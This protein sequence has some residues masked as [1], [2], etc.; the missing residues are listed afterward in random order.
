MRVDR[1]GPAGVV[2]VVAFFG[3]I[4]AVHESA[5]I[6]GMVGLCLVCVAGEKFELEQFQSGS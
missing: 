3:A 4:L 1:R 5:G 6:A 2:V